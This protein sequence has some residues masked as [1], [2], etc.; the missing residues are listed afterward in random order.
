[1][2]NLN[3]LQLLKRIFDGD[4]DTG[5]EMEA[6]TEAEAVSE[7]TIPVEPA[8]VQLTPYEKKLNN[9]YIG[10]FTADPN[11]PIIATQLGTVDNQAQ[12][13]SMGAT[14]GY[15]YAILQGGNVCLGANNL[16]F[17]TMQPVSRSSCNSVCDESSA[18]F[19]GGASSNQIYATSLGIAQE[20]ASSVEPFNKLALKEL[21]NFASETK[22][23]KSIRQNL[24]QNDML[25]EKPVNKY[26]L[27]LSVMIIVLLTYTIIEY[28]YKK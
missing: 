18:G 10:C 2:S 15:D 13:I 8:Q 5:V 26:N 21:E 14:A 19:C 23:L 11:N 1:M 24:S 12:C 20:N 22:E 7:P 3:L 9:L 16:N 17:S 6:E 28:V 25:C 27:F 4:I